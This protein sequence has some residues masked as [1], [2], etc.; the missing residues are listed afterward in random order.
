MLYY[1]AQF[2]KL[3]FL[4]NGM[5]FFELVAVFYTYMTSSIHGPYNIPFFDVVL[6]LIPFQPLSLLSNS[7]RIAKVPANRMTSVRPEGHRKNAAQAEIIYRK[8]FPEGR[9][10]TCNRYLNIQLN[11]SRPISSFQ[12]Y[13]LKR[14]SKK[15]QTFDRLLFSD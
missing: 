12:F 7:T 13:I 2:V 5:T 4:L 14:R 15:N 8:V 1:R 6:P 9:C 3:E 10:P 11:D